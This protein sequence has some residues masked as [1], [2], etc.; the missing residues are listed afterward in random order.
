MITTTRM[1]VNAHSRSLLIGRLGHGYALRSV[2]SD[3]KWVVHPAI[4]GMR[5]L[6]THGYAKIKEILFDNVV[7]FE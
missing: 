5:S 2:H 4:L 3:F 6:G 1:T 7:R